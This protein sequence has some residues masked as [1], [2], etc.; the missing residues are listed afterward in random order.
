[1]KN[2]TLYNKTV[3]ILVQAYFKNTLQHTN[4]FACAVGNMIA[5]NMGIKFVNE[6][7]NPDSIVWE[8]FKGYASV[9]GECDVQKTA[10]YYLCDRAKPMS[11]EILKQVKATGYTIHQL[12]TIEQAFESVDGDLENEDQWMFNGLMAV[13][14]VL[15]IIHENTSSQIT[16]ETKQK[17]QKQLAC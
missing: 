17:F 13:I 12:R 1:M 10:V 15:D 8:G 4:C 5:G 2:E 11:D 3:D 9:S 16:K 7:D 14:D 6:N